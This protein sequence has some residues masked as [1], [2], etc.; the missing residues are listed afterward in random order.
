MGSGGGERFREM[1]MSKELCDGVSPY[2]ESTLRKALDDVASRIKSSS[3]LP[4]RA[5]SRIFPT[6]LLPASYCVVLEGFTLL[7]SR[8]AG[9]VHRGER[10][11][12]PLVS[13]E[14]GGSRLGVDARGIQGVLE[15]VERGQGLRDD[16]DTDTDT[17]T[18]GDADGGVGGGG[19]GGGGGGKG[20]RKGGAGNADSRLGNDGVGFGLVYLQQFVAGFFSP[21][22]DDLLRWVRNNCSS[23][24]RRAVVALGVNFDGGGAN[25]GLFKH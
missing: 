22:S 16:E 8:A 3:L 9:I 1:W 14:G 13:V 10:D 4:P 25:A 23:Y 7:P 18:D 21:K 20:G 24:R 11:R 19:G 15:D 5:L 2:L 12:P 6:S 17:D